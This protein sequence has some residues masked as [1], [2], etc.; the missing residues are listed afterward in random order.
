MSAATTSSEGAPSA[1]TAS[2]TEK[3]AAE[4]KFAG[5]G[6]STSLGIQDAARAAKKAREMRQKVYDPEAPLKF[7]GSEWC[8]ASSSSTPPSISPLR[9]QEGV[10]ARIFLRPAQLLVLDE[11]SAALDPVAEHDMYVL[12]RSLRSLRSRTQTVPTGCEARDRMPWQVDGHLCVDRFGA[13]VLCQPHTDITHC[14]HVATHADRVVALKD[15]QVVR[16]VPLA[17]TCRS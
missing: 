3:S 4:S 1:T 8:A 5:G 11:F 12:V 10:M 2:M 16:L 17:A 7:S 15:S 9:R 14:V 6:D 13:S